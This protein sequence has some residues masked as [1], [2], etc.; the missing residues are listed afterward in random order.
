MLSILV[1]RFLYHIDCGDSETRRG[2]NCNFTQVKLGAY[3]S[4]RDGE[5]VQ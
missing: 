3:K 4:D 2:Q 5:G 1:L